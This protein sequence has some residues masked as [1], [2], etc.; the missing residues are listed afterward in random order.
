MNDLLRE[1]D[2]GFDQG[3]KEYL[4]G[5]FSGVKL[6]GTAFSD[7]EPMPDRAGKKEKLTKEEKL[8]NT[9]HPLD[10]FPELRRKALENL[11]PEPEDIYRFKSNG[12]FWLAPVHDGYMCRL[13]IPGGLVKAFQFRELGRI[14]REIASGYVQITTRSNVQIRIVQAK[15]TTELLRRIESIGLHARG[16]GAD[17]IRNL[18]ISPTAGIDPHELVDT[19]PYV[20][21]LSQ[22]IMNDREFY[23]LPRKFNISFSGGGLI[24]TAE[25]TN[26]IGM[27][28]FRMG[29]EVSFHVLLGGVTG[30][31]EFAEH[32]GV[33]C[34]PEQ[35]VEVAASITKVFARNGNRGNRGK[36]R[37]VYLLKDWGFEKFVTEVEKELGYELERGAVDDP[38]IE[39]EDLPEVPHAHLGVH[40][41]KQEGL[42]YIGLSTPVGLVDSDVAE[43]IADIA[44]EFGDGELRL[45][46]FENI[47]IPN[48]PQQKLAAAKAA[49]DEAGI[50]FGASNLR[51]GLV[52]CTGNRYCKFSAADT[53]GHGVA[54]TEFLDGQIELDQPINIHVTGCPHSCAQH[55]IGDIGLLGCKVE[56]KGGESFEGFHLFVGGGFGHRKNFGRQLFK[57]LRAGA[58][59]QG[60][61]L[62]LLQAYKSGSLDGQGFQEWVLGYP[63]E[64]LVSLVEGRL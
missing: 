10:A 11:P 62:A 3:Q 36:A 64:E 6:R 14:A 41:Q 49:L 59:L 23:N 56:G 4:E 29:G 5:F 21:D 48:I 7:V 9:L 13:R 50:S 61:V 20:R 38:R 39:L 30:H 60:H 32:S 18:T 53:K 45:T 17:N 19:A 51:G 43:K 47:L 42:S 35:V 34:K 28:A 63:I 57:S 22:V 33:I 12:I 52:A 26:D 40:P 37:L 16:S 31:Q 55:Y 25:D 58:E 46:I 8:K 27:R 2:Q 1:T 44:E 54:L 24:S 15:D